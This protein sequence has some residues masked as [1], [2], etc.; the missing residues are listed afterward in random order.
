LPFVAE[1]PKIFRSYLSTDNAKKIVV[2]GDPSVEF[3]VYND[4]LKLRGIKLVADGSPEGKTAFWTKPL[5]TGC[6]AALKREIC[7]RL[8]TSLQLKVRFMTV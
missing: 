3:N 5:L 4:R 7:A 6:R 1:V 2:L 8:R